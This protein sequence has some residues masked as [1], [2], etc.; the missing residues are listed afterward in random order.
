MSQNNSKYRRFTF[1]RV[2]FYFS[3]Y[4]VSDYCPLTC[5][6][7]ITEISKGG[8]GGGVPEKSQ[9]IGFLSN[10]SS[11]PLKITKLPSQHSMLGHHRTACETP[12]NGG[13][14]AGRCWPA[15]RSIWILLS[16]TL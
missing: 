7:F 2:T 8:G 1:I 5:L 13:S 10:S 3:F 4:Y 16:S 6:A 15:Y 11:D 14:L 9:N 12:L